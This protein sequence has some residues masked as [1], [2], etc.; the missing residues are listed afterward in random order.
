MFQLSK[1]FSYYVRLD[2]LSEP[3]LYEDDLE[4][5]VRCVIEEDGVPQ[6]FSKIRVVTNDPDKWADLT[7][8]DGYLRR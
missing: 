4:Y 8:G 1:T 7:D 3:K 6:G 2:V 5:Q